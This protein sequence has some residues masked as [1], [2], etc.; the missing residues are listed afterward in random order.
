MAQTAKAQQTRLTPTP[1]AL[2]KALEQSANQ[3]QK[4]ADAFG[5]VVPSVKPRT[6]TGSRNHG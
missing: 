3:A 2:K 4:L 6:T 5:L 1:K